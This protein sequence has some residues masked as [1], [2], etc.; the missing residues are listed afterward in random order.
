MAVGASNWYSLG[1]SSIDADSASLGVVSWGYGYDF[2]MVQFNIV[3]Y[4]VADTA[5]FIFNQDLPLPPFFVGIYGDRHLY[6]AVGATTLTN[7]QTLD[8]SI[9][10]IAGFTTTLTQAG[11]AFITGKS[12]DQT[13]VTVLCNTGTVSTVS[14]VSLLGAGSYASA[15]NSS[16][17]QD[18]LSVEIKTSG[19][20]NMLA[21]SG[22]SVFGA[23]AS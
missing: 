4:N 13:Q 22:F 19:G 3:G 5:G 8:G 18:V 6:V 7:S 9:I 2:L 21:G 17:V 12:R 23:N 14:P 15:T 20:N 10:R 16:V 1:A 11:S